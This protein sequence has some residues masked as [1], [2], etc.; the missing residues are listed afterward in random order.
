MEVG[1][2]QRSAGSGAGVLAGGR[3]VAA[4]RPGLGRILAG[5]AERELTGMLKQ[6]D[7]RVNG[8]RPW[9]IQVHDRRF[10]ARVLQQESLGLGDSYVEGW[11]DCEAVDELTHRV[12]RADVPSR[13]RPS[14][15]MI[16]GHLKARFWNLQRG[17]GGRKVATIHYDAGND[18]FRSMLGPTMNYSCAYWRRAATLDE[19]QEHKMQLIAEKLRLGPGDR[20]LDIGCGWGGLLRFAAERYGCPGVGVTISA[21]QQRYASEWCRGLPVEVLLADYRDP[22]LA[23]HGPFTKVVSVGMYEHV[24]AKNHRRMLQIVTDLLPEGGLF[25]L[26]TFGRTVDASLDVWVDRHVFP[27]SYLPTI[28]DIGR[29]SHGLLVME[30][31]HNFG[32]DYDRTLMAWHEGFERWAE[33][34]GTALSRERHRAWRYYLLTFAGAFRAR[35]RIQLWQVVFSRNGILGGYLAPR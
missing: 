29:A 6:A 4:G 3:F 12:L 1:P 30:D 15:P 19:A 17:R 20:L 16:L 21:E 8:P 9:D 28:E 13:I 7:V 18:L 25:L 23:R 10:F 14:L 33:G 26:H 11:W 22:A 2:I 34:Q 35:T 32:A 24:G 27:N 31:W 5:S